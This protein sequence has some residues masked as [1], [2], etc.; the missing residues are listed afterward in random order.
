MRFARRWADGVNGSAPVQ[1]PPFTPFVRGHTNARSCHDIVWCTSIA[2]S[3]L[4]DTV[5][6][7]N[8]VYNSVGNTNI[9]VVSL[10][11]P[12]LFNVEL[13]CLLKF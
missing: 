10:K 4:G 9:M 13:F 11:V 8:S 5:D 7:Q 6:L 3:V 12:I 1:A 2:N